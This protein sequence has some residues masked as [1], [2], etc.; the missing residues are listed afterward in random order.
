MICI[1]NFY[2]PD[3]I[4]LEI[5]A[6]LYLFAK[7]YLYECIFLSS[8]GFMIDFFFS[9]AFDDQWKFMFLFYC[10][11]LMVAVP[12]SISSCHGTCLDYGD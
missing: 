1:A 5:Y 10:L 2:A 8:L 9:L 4:I 3:W 6:N 7:V 12:Q 11:L